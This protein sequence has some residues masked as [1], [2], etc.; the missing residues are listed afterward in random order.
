MNIRTTKIPN[1]DVFP[2]KHENSACFYDTYISS[3]ET[4]SYQEANNEGQLTR[5]SSNFSSN[6]NY[7]TDSNGE[8]ANINERRTIS[9]KFC[10]KIFLVNNTTESE[11]S[12]KSKKFER[13]YKHCWN[14]AFHRPIKIWHTS[15]EWT[16]AILL[17]LSL[18]AWDM[19]TNRIGFK[20]N[21]KLSNAVGNLTI[22][23][24]RN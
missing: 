22:D 12:G 4:K 18:I 16:I 6:F 20:L 9:K 14:Y 11:E 3:D 24:A 7:A 13:R 15:K 17:K 23:G 21:K 1:C 19:W 2:S 5:S 10:L 8:S